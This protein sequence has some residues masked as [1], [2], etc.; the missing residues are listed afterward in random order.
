MPNSAAKHVIVSYLRQQAPGYALLVDAP[1]GS[2]KTHIIKQV[3]KCTDD[4]TRLYVTLYDVS[5]PEAFDWALVRAMNPWSERG[6]AGWLNRIKELASGITI[7]GSSVDLNKVNITEIALGALPDTLIFDDIER[8]G[9]NHLQLS[10]LINRFVEHQ[11]K[12]V[13]LIANSGEHKDKA[14]FVASREKLIGQSI[15]LRPEL[16]DAMEAFWREAPETQGRSALKSRQKLVVKTFE[17]AGHQNLRLLLRAMRDATTMLDAVSPEMV[18]FN[19]AMDR[20]VGTFLALHMAY[21]R[22]QLSKQDML[23]RAKNPN[24]FGSKTAKEDAVVDALETAQAAHPDCDIRISTNLILSVRLG[25]SLIVDGYASPSDILDGLRSTHQFSI[26]AEQPDWVRLWNW[27][28]EPTKD[29][30]T[31]LARVKGLIENQ[32]ITIPGQ[33]LQLYAATKFMARQGAIDLNETGVAGYFRKYI[34]LLAKNKKVPARVPSTDREGRNYGYRDENGTCSFGGYA[35]N[36]SEVDRGIIDLMKAQQDEALARKMP[37]HAS[38]LMIEFSSDLSAFIKKFEFTSPGIN[39]SETPV[40]HHLDV[41][42]AAAAFLALFGNSRDDAESVLKLLEKRRSNHRQELKEEWDW[43][44]KFRKI[45]IQQARDN[46]QMLG[47][48]V[49]Q[50]FEW[51]LK[52]E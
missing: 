8:C 13:I 21:H 48:Q 37:A 35:F 3:T 16:S 33:I 10:G 52:G 29:L 5:S 18:D 12:R 43:I 50:Y 39:F 24:L 20:L 45:S 23:D 41:G 51:H 17:E 49:A 6:A 47:A 4:P 19:D 28:E 34:L 38:E 30:E 46:S 25:F 32:D 15:T 27:A 44:D 2:G 9:L 42:Q 22:G 7:F 36:I 1:W 26:P 14:S 11:N 31:V 40:F